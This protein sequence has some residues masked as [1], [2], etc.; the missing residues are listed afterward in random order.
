LIIDGLP[1]RHRAD[2]WRSVRARA[3][4]SLGR[5]SD[6][7]QLGREAVALARDTDNIDLRGDALMALAEVLRTAQRPE[8]AVPLIGEAL[9]LYEQKGNVVS[10]GRARSLLDELVANPAPSSPQEQ[11]ASF[12]SRIRWIGPRTRRI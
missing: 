5:P 1:S 4:A 6:G 11:R 3:I 9:R 10:A 8:E 7:E 2:L 12:A